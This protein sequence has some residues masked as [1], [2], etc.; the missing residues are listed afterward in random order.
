MEFNSGST[1][2][3]DENKP[4]ALLTKEIFFLI[5]C[6]ISLILGSEKKNF[7]SHRVRVK[8]CGYEGRKI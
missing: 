6:H 4:C 8:V 2:I 1:L 3:M 7:W 5:N